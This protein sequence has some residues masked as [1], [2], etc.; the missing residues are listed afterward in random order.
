MRLL[1][2]IRRD[3]IAGVRLLVRTPGFSATAIATLAIA[4]GANTAVFAV[5][6]ALLF[7]PTPVALP[8][9]LG[10][11]DTGPS[12]TSWLNYEDIRSR[13][14]AF[15]DVLSTRQTVTTLATSGVPEA[16]TGQITSPNFFSVLGIP[17]AIG[18]TYA[19]AD[20]RSDLVVL[21]DHVW[22]VRFG[23]ASSI[24]GQRLTIGGRPLEVVGV[25][26]RQFRGLAP[27]GLHPDFWSPVDTVTP[28]RSLT[29][30]TLFEFDVVGRLKP[31]VTHQ[32]ATAA[33]RVLAAQLKREHPDLP[34]DFPQTVVVPIEGVEAFRGMSGILLP[35]F[36]FLGLMAV[37]SGFVLLIGCAN[38]AGL[39]VSRANARQREVA[40]RLALG[41]GRRRL[42][43]QLLT[44]SLV[45]AIVGGAAGLALTIWL[46]GAANSA[47]ALLPVPVEFDLRIDGRV[48][49]YALGLS[50]L[51]CVFF[52]LA[53]AWSATRLDLVS[54]LKD[55]GGSTARQ[56]MRRALVV[57]QVAM[58]TALLVWSGLFVNSLRHI[59]AVAPGFDPAGVVIAS[60]EL[61]RGATTDAEGEQIFV[62]WARRVGASRTV[63]VSGLALVVPLAL[64]GREDFYVS[65]PN[66]ETRRRVVAN[67]LTPG[68]FE[69]VRI[70]V[71][72]GR[73]FT[74]DDREGA[75]HVAIVNDTLSRQLWNGQALGQQ[76]RYGQKTLEVVGVVRDSKY[77]T[78]GETV[79]PTVYLPFR[80]TYASGMTLHARTT[81]ID[82]TARFM[83]EEMRRLAPNAPVSVK[84]MSDAVAVSVVPAQVGAA[85]TGLFGL[86]AMLLSAMGVYGLVSFAVGQRKR[87]FA[88]RQ[89]VGATA[90]DIVRLILG[91][92]TR[93]ISI[94]LTLG[95]GFGGVGAMALGGFLTGV[96]PFDPTTLISVTAVV[97]IAAF[98]AG[99]GPAW[100]AA[101]VRPLMALRDQ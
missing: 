96:R 47:V 35:V 23:S 58:C 83:V 15:V 11:V 60:A 45:L 67:R 68:W 72:S 44:E 61:E 63:E 17:A 18:R 69:T 65:L 1:D 71:V 5:V 19:P 34:E 100:R 92:N 75:P 21:S 31:S 20:T 66:D 9:E 91:T 14:D 26:P 40:V 52:G 95:L 86:V 4:I 98:L 3:V 46:V 24:L 49:A 10:R 97:V 87:E 79:A 59:S 30:R 55:E 93:L 84:R 43:R 70:P 62:E 90:Q 8:Q 80:Q 16:L 22:R 13:N 85:A 42:L 64:T 32:Q 2:S 81:D 29:D 88:I 41:A 28:S 77:A 57:G 50:T 53:P 7:K 27:P 6:N 48:F 73:D 54:S 36:A 51:A 89:A 37:V 82:G 101:R 76:L 94:G 12:L 56:R 25:M 39:L 38:I 78:I 99:L 33:L 74:W